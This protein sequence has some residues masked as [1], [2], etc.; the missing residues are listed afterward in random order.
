VA[1]LRNVGVLMPIRLSDSELDAVMSA[2]RP[3][4]PDL[5]DPFLRAANALAGPGRD[6]SR[7]G[8]P[9]LQRTAKAVLP[10][11]GSRAPHQAGL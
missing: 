10:A 1:V 4:D 2:A 9:C 11:A 8:R 3:L 6:R 7:R 5:R